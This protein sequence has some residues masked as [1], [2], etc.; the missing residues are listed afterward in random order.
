MYLD[1]TGQ[2]LGDLTPRE[3]RRWV[4]E[5]MDLIS[6]F[7]YR[8]EGSL[9]LSRWI[10]SF[11]GLEEAAWWSL[12]DPWPFLDMAARTTGQAVRALAR[13]IR[14]RSPARGGGGE[15]PEAPPKHPER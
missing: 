13:R 1:L 15:L 7:D 12:R 6:F 4:I 14:R 10:A 3:G 9:T 11:R 8:A 2:P 5:D